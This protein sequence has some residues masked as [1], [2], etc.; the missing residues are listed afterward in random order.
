M[1]YF[2]LFLRVFQ[3]SSKAQLVLVELEAHTP[4]A[5][6]HCC[7]REALPIPGSVLYTG[8]SAE[9]KL[10]DDKDMFGTKANLRSAGSIREKTSSSRADANGANWKSWQQGASSS[11]TT[12]GT[13]PACYVL[14]ESCSWQHL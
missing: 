12:T 2:C 14:Q 10:E 1:A 9:N 7:S 8:T 13:P 4:R 11:A 6:P 3:A 5:H